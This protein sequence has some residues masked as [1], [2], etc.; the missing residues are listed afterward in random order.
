MSHKSKKMLASDK[1]KLK[2]RSEAQQAIQKLFEQPQLLSAKW[3]ALKLNQ[4]LKQYGSY[5][6]IPESVLNDVY[7][8][9]QIISL[10]ASNLL[11]PAQKFHVV[12]RYS[13]QHMDN[14]QETAQ[15]RIDYIFDEAV[16]LSEIL[17]AQNDLM[18][19]D[20]NI[21]TPFKGL[22]IDSMH[23]LKSEGFLGYGII[24]LTVEVTCFAK[25]RKTM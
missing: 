12:Y 24:N 5:G 4:A 9:R 16:Q 15:S 20:A 3:D 10:I 11:H 14:S 8:D 6:A 23:I 13:L 21:P 1:T 19:I 25:L 22:T 17:S 7:Q 18:R 2:I